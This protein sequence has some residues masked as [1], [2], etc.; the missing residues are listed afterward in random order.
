MGSIPL[1]KSKHLLPFAAALRARGIKAHPLLKAASLPRNCLDDPETL[2]PS[3]CAGPFRELVAQKTD[4][5]SISIEITQ[6]F[7]FEDM[8]DFGRALLLEPT[9]LGSIDRFRKLV[10]T[11]TSN[12]FIDVCL[13]SN[14]DLWFGQRILSQHEPGEWH[15]NLYVIGWMLKI[16]RQ[17]DPAW[18]PAQILMRSEATPGH[19]KSIEMLGSAARFEQNYSGF[20]VPASMLALPTVKC[21]TQGK[22]KGANSWPTL[23]ADSYAKSLK[24]V[25]GTYANDSW[26][27]ID[28][29][30]E[31]TDQ[32]VRTIQRRLSM[33]QTTYSDLVQQCRAEMAGDLLENSGIA[34]AEIAHQLGYRSQGNFTRAFYRWARVSPSEFRKHRLKNRSLQFFR[35]YGTGTSDT[36]NGTQNGTDT[37]GFS[38]TL[39]GTDTSG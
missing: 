20:M 1:S 31:V 3:V 2:I 18:S 25:I 15:S 7:Q 13:Q 11:E 39:N 21:S 35:L 23:L 37:S 5:P 36:L 38:D 27:S 22:R 16:V 33:E 24:Q 8:G 9:L 26:L 10:G 19:Y 32:S 17:V 4:C 6:Q 29:A 28:E 12:V 14:G 30:S 34:I